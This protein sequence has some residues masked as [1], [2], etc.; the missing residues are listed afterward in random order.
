ME[1]SD[2]CDSLSYGMRIYHVIYSF[3]A[4]NICMLRAVFAGYV[5]DMVLGKSVK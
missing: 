5:H 3:N 2:S 4:A 1:V